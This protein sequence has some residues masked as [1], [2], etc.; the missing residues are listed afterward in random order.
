MLRR[1]SSYQEAGIKQL[2]ETAESQCQEINMQNKWKLSI[3]DQRKATILRVS[4]AFCFVFHVPVL[5]FPS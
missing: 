5:A 4:F 2:P 3:S 1:G